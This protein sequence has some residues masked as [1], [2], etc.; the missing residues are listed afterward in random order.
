MSKPQVT[1][2]SIT[3][4][5]GLSEETHAYTAT[6]YVDGKKFATV[7][8]PGHGGCDSVHPIDGD[9]NAV[10]ELESRIK[11]TYPATEYHGMTIEE[12]LEGLCCKAVNEWLFDR[13]WKRK[14]KRQFCAIKDG[15]LYTWPTKYKVATATLP[16]FKEQFEAQ[17]YQVL[18]GLPY[19]EAKALIQSAS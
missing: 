10:K 18:N 13:E 8:N 3:H 12:S 16:K 5:A 4:N 17:G 6:I 11:A 2:K 14:L 15:A 7:T 9:W 1:L 19:D